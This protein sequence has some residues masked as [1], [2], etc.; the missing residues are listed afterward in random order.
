MASLT[1]TSTQVNNGPILSDRPGLLHKFVQFNLGPD[2]PGSISASVCLQMIAIPDGARILD[3]TLRCTGIST[4]VG[5]F[6][7]GDGS[8]T[9][10][11]CAAI[12]ITSSTVVTRLNAAGGAGFL[13]SLTASHVPATFDTIDLTF[14][15]V[16]STR[17]MCIEM[18][19]FYVME[20]R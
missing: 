18:S 12:S 13:V 19:A 14:V 8:S 1:I 2:A 7:V 9:A 11:F 6:T 10:R 15:A 17:T 16:T 4:Q 20:E 3:L 5:N